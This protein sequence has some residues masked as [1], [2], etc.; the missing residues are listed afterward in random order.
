MCV[1]IVQ[2]KFGTQTKHSLIAQIY[3][4]YPTHANTPLYIGK[5]NTRN[6]KG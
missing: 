1:R 2:K 3:N 4:D 6:I 5:L